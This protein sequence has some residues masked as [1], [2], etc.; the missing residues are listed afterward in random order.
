MTESKFDI[1]ITKLE[2]KYGNFMTLDFP[3]RGEKPE[4]NTIT[5][6]F[7]SEEESCLTKV[8]L[9]KDLKDLEID[10]TSLPTNPFTS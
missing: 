6:V 3:R 10:R 2:T 1:L 8:K 4:P 9:R 5:L 7:F